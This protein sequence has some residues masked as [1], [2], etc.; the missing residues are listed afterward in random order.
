MFVSRLA[1]CG[2]L[3]L[4]L[5][6]LSLDEKPVQYL[7]PHPHY[8]PLLEESQKPGVYYPPLLESDNW[9]PKPPHQG[10]RPPRPRPKPLLE[11]SQKPPGVYYPPLLESDNWWPKP[12]HQ[13]PRPPRPR[14]KP[15]QSLTDDTTALREELSL[16][17]EAASGPAAAGVGDGWRSDSKAAATPQKL[18]KGRGAAATSA[19][20]MRDLRTDGK[21][22]RQKWG[23]M[24][25]PKGESVGVRGVGGGGSRRLKGLAK[26]GAAKG[27]FGLPLDR[28]GST[29]GLGC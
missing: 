19:R 6:A 25:P 24:V 10:P 26:K 1:A 17:P 22:W 4:A 27:C 29:S 3:L 21:Q 20:L 7:P 8:P 18:A 11:E 13:G 23:R 28:I 9:W 15:S 2:L 16:R 14:P 12:P 5:P